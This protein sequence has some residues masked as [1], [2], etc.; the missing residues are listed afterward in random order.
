MFA[1][2]AAHHDTLGIMLFSATEPS[3]QTYL[4]MPGLAWNDA[5]GASDLTRPP[6]RQVSF[7]VGTALPL[8]HLRLEVGDARSGTA[9]PD[10]ETAH[11]G[12]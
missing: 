1:G 3:N 12:D 2:H 7:N 9:A 11:H 4:R 6:G 8:L 10:L 5:D